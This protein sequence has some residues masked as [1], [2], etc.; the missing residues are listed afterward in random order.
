MERWLGARLKLREAKPVLGTRPDVHVLEVS[1]MSDRETAPKDGVYLL[2]R[3][4]YQVRRGEPLPPGARFV[5]ANDQ[6]AEQEATER[7][8]RPRR[9]LVAESAA[10]A[11]IGPTETTE[12]AGPD[13]TA[14]E[15]AERQTRARR[16]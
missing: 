13:T 3:G 5:D 1:E 4:R 6:Q 14:T 8:Q 9:V 16:S 12:S 11:G 7:R 15:S 2:G 10:A